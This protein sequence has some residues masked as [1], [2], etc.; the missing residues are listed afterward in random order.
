MPRLTPTQYRGTPIDID[1]EPFGEAEVDAVLEEVG[2]AFPLLMDRDA[3]RTRLNQIATLRSYVLSSNTEPTPWAEQDYLL[4]L[5]WAAR[6]LAELVPLSPVP[7]DDEGRFDEEPPFGVL[8]FLDE[9]MAALINQRVTD[10]RDARLKRR[11]NLNLPLSNR[12]VSPPAISASEIFG[13]DNPREI[14]AVA[15]E[16]A[17]LLDQ[18]TT[19]AL[20]EIPSVQTRVG[21]PA[22][23][24][25]VARPLMELYREAFGRTPAASRSNDNTEVTGPMVRFIK[26]VCDILGMAV[27]GEAIAKEKAKYLRQRQS[28]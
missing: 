12:Q 3:F 2:A 19:L 1:H 21:R 15:S 4:D 8:Q 27:S 6:Q 17:R 7:G 10:E 18:A 13:G 23:F 24:G 26:S 11:Q 14:L 25:E 5:R 9:P 28:E 16:L 22:V 20:N